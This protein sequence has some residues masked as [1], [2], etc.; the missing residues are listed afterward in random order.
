VAV[1]DAD[2]AHNRMLRPPHVA[3]LAARIGDL[4]D[5]AEAP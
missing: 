2:G 4:L 3:A 1:V 5:A